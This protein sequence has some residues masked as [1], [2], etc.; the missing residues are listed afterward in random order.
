MGRGKEMIFVRKN[1]KITC[2]TKG[3]A[4]QRLRYCIDF[5]RIYE[6]CNFAGTKSM[7]WEWLGMR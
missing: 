7:L 2:L 6:Q 4:V 3:T 1:R 5:Y